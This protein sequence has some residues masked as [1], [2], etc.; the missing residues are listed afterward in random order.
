MARTVMFTHTD[1]DGAV[2]AILFRWY[3]EEVMGEH[4]EI[5][6]CDYSDVDK[7]LQVFFHDPDNADKNAL[8]VDIAPQSVAAWV[9]LLNHKGQVWVHDHHKTSEEKF[10]AL[11]KA[12]ASIAEKQFQANTFIGFDTSGAWCGAG[13]LF[14]AMLGWHWPNDDA[15]MDFN[16]RFAKMVRLT[17]LWDLHVGVDTP[18]FEEAK[19]FNRLFGILGREAF[20]L[21]EHFGA[22]KFFVSTDERKLLE[23]DKKES[24][25]YCD[26]SERITEVAFDGRMTEVVADEYVSDVAERLLS[27]PGVEVAVIY[28]PRRMGASVRARQ[29][30][31]FNARLY[32]E[33]FG[34]G[35]HD[36]AAGFPLVGLGLDMYFNYMRR[37]AANE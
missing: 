23:A 36:K 18:E 14:N 6:F 2:A 29:D 28:S 27:L 7:R 17:N 16:D 35:G 3:S 22:T 9:S 11:V 1:L 25:G 24:Q 5:H 31:T 21:P 10:Q 33:Q 15:M 26:E 30:S 12:H 8:I 20:M 19:D 34:G 32:A 13:L 37:R 4:I